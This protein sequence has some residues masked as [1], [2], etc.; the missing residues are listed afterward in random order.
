MTIL[1]NLKI[2]EKIISF[3]SQVGKEMK[4]AWRFRPGQSSENGLT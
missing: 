1:S 4:M 3:A 2:N